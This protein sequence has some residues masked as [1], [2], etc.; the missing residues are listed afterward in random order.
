MCTEEPVSDVAAMG[1][2]A[3]ETRE[4]I[5]SS[6]DRVGMFALFAEGHSAS[7][8]MKRLGQLVLLNGSSHM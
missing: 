2:L 3:A 7:M 6:A 1:N 5:A 8:L 4:A